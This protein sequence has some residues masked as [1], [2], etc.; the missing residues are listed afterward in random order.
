MHDLVL[1]EEYLLLEGD[2]PGHRVVLIGSESLGDGD[3]L[4]GR[5][6]MLAFLGELATGPMLPG[7]II[8]YNGGARLAAPGSPAVGDLCSLDRH[9]TDIL[10]CAESLASHGTETPLPAGRPAS[11]AEITDCL[12]KASTVIRP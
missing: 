7:A 11:L 6:L 5:Q 1:P 8:F 4:L 3:D 12:M 2:S 9:G 10:V